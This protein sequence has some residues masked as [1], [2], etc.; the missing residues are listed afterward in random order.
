MASAVKVTLPGELNLLFVAGA[1]IETSKI[2]DLERGLNLKKIVLYAEEEAER[3]DTA[4]GDP[5]PTQE[6]R[7]KID[8]DW[9]SKWRSCA[10]DVKREEM[11]RL[12]ANLI[13]GEVSQPGSY[14]LHTIDFLS[15]MSVRDAALI[16]RIAPYHTVGGIV[17]LTDDYLKSQEISFPELLY[18]D[19]IGILNGVSAGIGGLGY[20]FGYSEFSGRAQSHIVC[21]RSVLVCDM[22]A[23]EAGLP[24]Q[25]NLG[26]YATTVIGKEILSL[27]PFEAN[28]SYLQLIA[29]KA[30]ELGAVKVE[31]GRLHPNGRQIL[32]L[33]VIA[34]KPAPID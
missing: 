13:A 18:L 26:V 9:L 4:Q 5:R 7:I 32:G 34:V 6:P 15:R 1:V 10:Q 22:G 2:D 3:L 24:K 33:H 17:K 25:I 28:E 29:D 14:S 11:Q 30:I 12:W 19:D 31:K 8:P 23:I 20:D 16:A 27:A 21:N